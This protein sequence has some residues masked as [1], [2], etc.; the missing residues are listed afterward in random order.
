MGKDEIE[1]WYAGR[2][3]GPGD[4]D[5][6]RQLAIEFC[7]DCWHLKDHVKKDATM[8]DAQV[9]HHAKSSP[10]IRL[11]GDVAN[12]HKHGGRKPGTT[13]ARVGGVDLRPGQTTKATFRI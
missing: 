6:W 4:S 5:G 11:A 3:D 8:S 13:T 9:E 7:E 12:T 1:R 10:S 2:T